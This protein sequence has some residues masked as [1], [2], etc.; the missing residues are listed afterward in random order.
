MYD[1]FAGLVGGRLTAYLTEV[2]PPP[3]APG[4]WA[5]DLGCGTGRHT[6]LLAGRFRE[7]LAVDVSGPML[8]QALAERPRE[9]V[10]YEQRDLCQVRPDSDGRFDLVFSAYA[11]H[12]LPEAELDATLAGIGEL[13]APGGQV[14]VV[15]VT[16]D[17]LLSAAA[18]RAQARAALFGD[19]LTR[20]RTVADAVALYRCSTH[21]GLL[22]HLTAD[23]PLPATEF[24]RRYSTV[25]PGAQF[26]P[27]D[28]GQ[29]LPAAGYPA[30]VVH[31]HNPA[32]AR[33]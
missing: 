14:I 6:A 9:N 12:H 2:L 33:R 25:F 7:V 1:R 19:L 17:R 4:G 15:D 3:W 31:W 10:S 21:P 27:L 8:D 26:T 5:V 13:V 11:L 32:P 24:H 20:R 22:A 18:L 30:T 16:A 29:R 23:R 28:P